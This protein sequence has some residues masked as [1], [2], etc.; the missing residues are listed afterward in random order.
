MSSQ[1]EMLKSDILDVLSKQ[2]SGGEMRTA[3]PNSTVPKTDFGLAGAVPKKKQNDTIKKDIEKALNNY[4]G[5]L[6]KLQQ[7]QSGSNAIIDEDE[8][9]K[10]LEAEKD[11]LGVD[12]LRIKDKYKISAGNTAYFNPR[13]QKGPGPHHGGLSSLKLDKFDLNKLSNYKKLTPDG[14]G[15]PLLYIPT[16][17]MLKKP[18]PKKTAKS[19]SK[20]LTLDDLD[21]TGLDDVPEKPKSKA[22]PKKNPDKQPKKS[23][24]KKQAQKIDPLHQVSKKDA[25]KS[26]SVNKSKKNIGFFEGTNEYGGKQKIYYDKDDQR[27]WANGLRRP[28][29]FY[30]TPNLS[31]MTF[32]KDNEQEW[33]DSIDN[34]KVNKLTDKKLKKYLSEEDAFLDMINKRDSPPP[35]DSPK[36]TTASKKPLTEYQQFVKEYSSKNKNLGKDLMKKAS[37]AWKAFK[38]T[39]EFEKRRPNPSLLVQDA[40]KKQPKKKSGRT[41]IQRGV[42]RVKTQKEADDIKKKKK[43]G[44]TGI[45]KVEQ[46][47]E[48][49]LQRVINTVAELEGSDELTD[50]QLEEQILLVVAEKQLENMK[51]KER[52]KYERSKTKKPLTTKDIKA[53]SKPKKEC[54]K[55]KELNVLTNRCKKIIK[56]RKTKGTSPWMKF[57]AKFRAENPQIK[58]KDVMKQA[59]IAY[60]DVIV[61]YKVDSDSE[62]ELPPPPDKFFDEDYIKSLPDPE[63][64]KFNPP[65]R[66]YLK[67]KLVE[68]PDKTQN[69]ILADILDSFDAMVKTLENV[70]NSST[71]KSEKEKEFNVVA[72]R[73]FEFYEKLPFIDLDALSKKRVDD[74]Y[75]HVKDIIANGYQDLISGIDVVEYREYEDDD[76]ITNAID[77][78]LLVP[79]SVLDSYV[80]IREKANQDEEDA[81]DP[82]ITETINL[83]SKDNLPVELQVTTAYEDASDPEFS[84]DEY[85]FDDDETVYDL[86][87]DEKIQSDLIEAEEKQQA[88]KER[89]ED[90][91]YQ[92]ID[93]LDI[94]SE[95]EGKLQKALEKIRDRKEEYEI[96]RKALSDTDS[97]A[98]IE[99]GFTEEDL[100]EILD[101]VNYDFDNEDYIGEYDLDFLPS[102]DE[103]EYVIDQD[104]MLAVLDE[105]EKNDLQFSRKP[106][107]YP[108]NVLTD[109]NSIQPTT[110]ANTNASAPRI[111]KPVRITE[112]TPKVFDKNGRKLIVTG[113]KSQQ[114]TVTKNIPTEKRKRPLNLRLYQEFLK[115]MR[116]Y[117]PSL[118][119]ADITALWRSNKDAYIDMLMESV[120]L[121]GGDLLNEEHYFNAFRNIGGVMLGGSF[122]DMCEGGVMGNTMYQMKHQ[123]PAFDRSTYDK[124]NNPYGMGRTGPRLPQVGSPLVDNIPATTTPTYSG[125]DIDMEDLSDPRAWAKTFENIGTGVY[126]GLKDVYKILSP[127][128]WLP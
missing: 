104:T 47:D 86:G 100:D 76:L 110:I 53:L 92:Q 126:E 77:N 122:C 107:N 50:E 11:D 20:K 22:K 74:S 81:R 106:S 2:I 88:I 60:K 7:R 118:S 121:S 52:K 26:K 54:P 119:R 31:A 90:L 43:S 15:V 46:T 66:N 48:Q 35:K 67:S 28:P 112:L 99:V 57:L 98:T 21:L 58:G 4:Y 85:D 128:S 116:K 9:N 8:Y 37:I 95:K 59:S 120:D 72:D 103:E 61:P 45:Q 39:P 71:R 108:K 91:Y 101:E 41:G 79:E 55:G 93:D 40:F 12:M 62:D 5:E 70:A 80:D 65:P 6:Y 127:L 73:A 14:F 125:S 16:E 69:E 78:Q 111:R 115:Q 87:Y 44:R 23:A 33:L 94:E 123:E 29:I 63:D 24:T 83:N 10:L 89:F 105:E 49:L 113:P 32:H 27:K 75:E 96:Q 114:R 124:V 38:K 97:E 102:D 19:K 109:E 64:S 1:N 34:K 84:E 30:L 56:K 3:Y 13:K 68:L 82:V 25:K 117:D 17:Y 42:V 36:K 18:D 51:P